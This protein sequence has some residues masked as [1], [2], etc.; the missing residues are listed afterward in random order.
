[1]IWHRTGAEAEVMLPDFLT[2]YYE[3]DTGPFRSLS[4]LS[5][6]DAAAL[7]A[8]LRDD[9]VFAGK[10]AADYLA[11]RHRAEALV[12]AAFIAKGG[13]PARMHPHYMILGACPWV[14]TWY[15][16]GRALCIPL[17]AF[18]AECVSFTYGDTFPALFFDDGKSYR[19]QVYTLA[20]LPDLVAQHGLPQEWNPDGR[21][22]PDRYIEAQVWADG[23]VAV[24]LRPAR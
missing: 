7:L 19:K 3:A 6:A 10:R 8:R 4:S 9:G 2:H 5:Q 21:R 17:D 12:R 13:R 1:M 11:R 16:D 20:E 14:C 18:P 23:P 24:Y 22:G 15:R